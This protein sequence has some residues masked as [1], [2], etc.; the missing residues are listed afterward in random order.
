MPPPTHGLIVCDNQS[1]VDKVLS[2]QSP[3]PTSDLLDAEWT[4]FDSLTGPIGNKSPSSTLTPDWDVLNEIRHSLQAL[5]FPPTIQH[6]KG[7]QDQQTPYEFL[8]LSA[9][10]NVDADAAAGAFQDQHGCDR[11]HVPMFPH[12][13]AQLQIHQGTVTH[14]YKSSI[15]YAAHGPPLLQ[16]IQQRNSWTPAITQSID[17][18]AHELALGRRIHLRVHLTKL[19]HDILPTNDY[20]SG[21]IDKRT[22]KCP[23]CPHTSEDR[24]HVL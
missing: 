9:Q 13:G 16:Y 12:A 6:I 24:D 3:F 1:L 4:P 15:R 8:P 5:P 22:E 7:H 18:R 20:A 10:L 11:P 23:S 19:V 17:W 14:N 21:W 2:Y